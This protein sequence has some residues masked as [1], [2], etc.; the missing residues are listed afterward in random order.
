MASDARHIHLILGGSRSGKS[1]HALNLA[2]TVPGERLFVA[3]SPVID[4]EYGERIERHRQERGARGWRHILEEEH[5]LT[6]AVQEPGE[7]SVVLIDCLTLWINN[8]LYRDQSIDESA[9][10]R[11]AV[12][13]ARAARAS[14]RTVILVSGEVGLGVVPENAMARKFGD[15]LGRCNQVIAAAAD[16]VVLVCSGIPLV[17]K[18]VAGTGG[19]SGGLP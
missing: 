18:D 19:Q 16:R 10:A 2:E 6:R 11:R 9:V 1:D 4:R 15:L 3:T 13:L 17:L 5:D 12:E 14:G 7:Y 8:L